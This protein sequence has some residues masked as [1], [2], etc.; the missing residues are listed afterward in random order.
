MRT[1]KARQWPE[2]PNLNREGGTATVSQCP[3][4]FTEEGT[5]GTARLWLWE[6][7]QQCSFK[8]TYVWWH[9]DSP[10]I[11]PTEINTSMQRN[12]YQTSVFIDCG[13]NRNQLE[14]NIS[15]LPDVRESLTRWLEMGL[16]EAGHILNGNW[17]SSCSQFRKF[18]RLCNYNLYTFIQ[19]YNAFL[20]FT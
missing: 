19:I 17:F 6:S 14:Q 5:A 4:N 8:S 20:F 2:V 15:V 1:T 7:P 3:R 13:E 9:S 12:R 11:C 16:T 18:I 10:G